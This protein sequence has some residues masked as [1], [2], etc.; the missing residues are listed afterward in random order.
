MSELAADV[1]AAVS[2]PEGVESRLGELEVTDDTPSPHTVKIECD[3]L[4]LAQGLDGRTGI[5]PAMGTRLTGI[6]NGRHLG[7]V[8]SRLFMR[9]LRERPVAQLDPGSLDSKGHTAELPGER[10]ATP[11]VVAATK[12]T[13]PRS[14]RPLL[15]RHHL[16]ARLDEDYRLALVSAP[17]GYGKTA[18]LASW[19]AGHRDRL[20]WLSCDPSDREPT[21]FMSGLLAAIAARWPGV[22][23]DAFALLERDSATT[24]DAAVA[25]ANELATIDAPGVVVVDDLHLAAPDPTVLTAFIDA[26][27]D[28][29]RFAAATRSD[30]PLSLSRLRLR[31]DL[32]ELRGD[33]LRFAPTE[34]SEFFALHDLSMTGE[35]MRRLHQLTEGWP[36]G[37]QLAAIALQRGA[38]HED[39]LTAF[40]GTDRAVSDFLVSELLSGLPPELVEFLAE[41][42]VLDVFDAELCAAV[43]GIEDSAALLDHLLTANLFVVPLDGQEGWYRYHHLFAAFLRAR[44]ASSGPTKLRAAHDRA[45]GALEDRG[46]DVGALQQALAVPDAYRAG[47]IVRA[48]LRRPTSRPDSTGVTVRAIRLWLDEYGA[49][50]VETDP[51]WVVE[52]VIGLTT[53]NDIDDVPAWL[54]RI[55]RAHPNADGEL[56]ALIE[57]AGAEHQQQRGQPLEAIVRLHTAAEAIGGIWPDH[58]PLSHLEASSASAHLQAGQAAEALAGIERALAHRVGSPVADKVH[59]PGI[60]A[61]AA[62]V[63]G[64]LTRADRLARSVTDAADQLGLGRHEP[65]RTFADLALA[66][67][68]LERHDHETAA[69]IIHRI[70]CAGESRHRP[71][72]QSLIT[73]HQAKVA[74]MLGDEMDADALLGQARRCYTEPDAAVRQTFGE[75]A[76]AQALRFDP[77]K[78]AP[79]ISA[80]DQDQVATQ[81]LRVRLALVDHD[82]RAAAAILADLP[83]ATTRRARV[84]RSVL[85]ALSV[86]ARDVGRA[87]SHLCEAL[88]AG[89]PERLIR[90]VVDQAPGVHHLLLSYAPAATQKSYVEDLLA[91]TSRILPLRQGERCAVARRTAQPPRDRRAALPVQP[92][93]LPRDRR[94]ALRLTEHPQV[95]RAKHFPQARGG[96]A[97]RRGRRRSMPGSD[98]SA[99]GVLSR[100]GR[101]R[102]SRRHH[103]PGAQTMLSRQARSFAFCCSNSASVITPCA[104]K[105]ASLDSSAAVPPPV[106]VASWT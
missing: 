77:S 2:T 54:E 50:M 99:T 31:G 33:D 90:T 85:C 23:D 16:S 18:A 105:S 20:A 89:Q 40:A 35:E 55:R 10:R 63:D 25:V 95:P 68:H 39:F 80:L 13:I 79:L 32:L 30:P 56:T 53:V 5:T 11:T 75:E 103:D 98:L 84:E 70:T 102:R 91:A 22:A 43:T 6:G 17:A 48:A 93:D 24:Y 7:A 47:R 92:A 72:L 26:L 62:A 74:R 59:G 67:I 8:D 86:L 94:H 104:F 78:A 36:A 15:P 1:P 64:E 69:R 14:R 28:G 96:V 21:R 101:C 49:A 73:L 88:D 60:A 41:T 38:G 76:V 3:R 52:L 4:E 87:N 106:V 45:C 29:F 100:P 97:R 58:G 12:L 42:S 71:M 81:V 66:E 27:P 19:A 44:L 82:D 46:D 83:P 34:M 61:L 9:Q 51:A 57:M 37:A 65:G